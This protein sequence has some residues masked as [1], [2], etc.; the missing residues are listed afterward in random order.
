MEKLFNLIQENPAS[1]SALAAMISA[2][3]ALIAIVL[4]YISLRMQ[5]RHNL[6][7][8][9]PIA[10]IE[11]SDYENLLSVGIRNS[12]VGPLIINQFEA[13]DKNGRLADNIIGLMPNLPNGFCWDTYYEN[14]KNFSIIPSQ[15][16]T[17]LK[18]TGNNEDFDFCKVRDTIRKCLSEIKIT[19]TYRDIYGRNM[20]KNH[21]DMKWFARHFIE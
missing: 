11:L 20:P 6:K 1:I 8:V 21:K 13:K 12:G 7:S 9:T 15:S 19:L 5:H 14:L 3:V 2:C 18:L 16:I 10:N 4:T 17:L